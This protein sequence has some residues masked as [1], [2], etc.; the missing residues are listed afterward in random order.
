MWLIHLALITTEIAVIAVRRRMARFL[1]VT[2]DLLF[3]QEQEVNSVQSVGKQEQPMDAQIV[4]HDLW[5]LEVP[6]SNQ[7]PPLNSEVVVC[8]SSSNNIHWQYDEN[9]INLTLEIRLVLMC[10]YLTNI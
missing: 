4:N 2:G 6:I 10:I 8:Y 5:V 7:R 3:H 1:F 9:F